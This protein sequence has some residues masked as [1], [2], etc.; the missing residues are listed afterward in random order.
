MHSIASRSVSV[1]SI[2]LGLVSGVGCDKSG[3][4]HY[5]YDEASRD[6][7]I[8]KG[9]EP[10]MDGWVESKCNGGA[11]AVASQGLKTSGYTFTK[12][13]TCAGLGFRECSAGR[14]TY[15]RTCS[16]D[17]PKA[18]ATPDAAPPADRPEAP[19]EEATVLAAPIAV[20]ADASFRGPADG[21]LVLQVFGDYQDPFTGR[22]WKTL[23]QVRASRP[24]LKVVFRHNPLSFHR[25]APLAHQA[26]LEARAQKGEEGFWAMHALL[27]ES[28]RDLGRPS[29]VALAAKVGLDVAAFEKALDSGAHAARLAEDVKTA[30]GAGLLVAPMAVVDTRILRGAQPADKIAAFLDARP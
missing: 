20:P 13:A 2:L 19:Q 23:E 28:P 22:L 14:G 11:L 3:T 9:L 7:S 1:A 15:Y 5:R 21:K 18:A 29:L 4:C 10:C 8:P 24:D 6:G 12:G 25:D 16:S 26:A 17:M 27:V 30:Q